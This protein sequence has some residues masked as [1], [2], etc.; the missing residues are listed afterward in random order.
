M[1]KRAAHEKRIERAGCQEPGHAQDR[2][3][4]KETLRHAEKHGRAGQAEE[5]RIG[6][7]VAHG[8]SSVS[9]HVHDRCRSKDHGDSEDHAERGAYTDLSGQH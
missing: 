4:H 9:E 3:D 2:V 7:Y 8:H 1:Q 6:D 5:N